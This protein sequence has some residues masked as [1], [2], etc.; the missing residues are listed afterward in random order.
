MDNLKRY[1]SSAELKALAKEH[2]FGR[3][4]TTIG[5]FIIVYMITMFITFFSTVFI[6]ITSIIGL[7]LNFIISFVISVMAGLF[8]SGE[9]YLYLK[10]SC[11]QRVTVSDVF[12]GFKL[13]PN[14]AILIQLYI[15]IFIYIAMLPMT[16]LSYMI[17]QNPGDA[18]LTLVYSLAIIF[19]GVVITIVTLIYSQAFYLLHD[20]PNYT[21]QELLAMSNKLMKG[22]KGRLF[23]LMVS[24]FP[25]LL[26]GLFS[27]GIAYLWLIPYINATNAEFFL[28]LIQNNKVSD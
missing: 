3:Y 24:F 1:K 4:G 10:I 9:K 20:F 21:A 18:V 12:Y 13:F 27:C 7:I 6:D 19:Y 16:I 28:D 14:K 5:A 23:Y 25:L 15:S 8:T 26:L 17:R 22:S 2:L 11:N